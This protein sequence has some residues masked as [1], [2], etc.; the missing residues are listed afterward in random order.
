[1]TEPSCLRCRFFDAYPPPK[2]GQFRFYD[3]ACRRYPGV[4]V[5]EGYSE[6]VRTSQPEKHSYEWCGEYDEERPR[7]GKRRKLKPTPMPSAGEVRRGG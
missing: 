1:V 7:R 5:Y 3:G 6:E 2:E 4:P